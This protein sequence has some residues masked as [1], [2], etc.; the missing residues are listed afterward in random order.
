M[1]H[2]ATNMYNT[3]AGS[4]KSTSAPAERR[5]VAISQAAVRNRVAQVTAKRKARGRSRGNGL[6]P[7]RRAISRAAT[8]HAMK[9]SGVPA[10]RKGCASNGRMARPSQPRRRERG[11][12][13]VGIRVVLPNEQ[14]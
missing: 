2:P 10:Y 5:L 3:A 4:S 12:E 7:F 6:W 1:H 14:G 8:V 9:S 11:E 13:G